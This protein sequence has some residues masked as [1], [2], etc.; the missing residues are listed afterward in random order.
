[1]G[2]SPKDRALNDALPE[3]KLL[4][5]KAPA[6]MLRHIPGVH[7]RHLVAGLA[8][9]WNDDRVVVNYLPARQ[10]KTKQA[11]EAVTTRWTQQELDLP[12]RPG[13]APIPKF[14]LVKPDSITERPDNSIA[15]SFRSSNLSFDAAFWLGMRLYVSRGED[16][17]LGT[18]NG[19]KQ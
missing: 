15:V 16:G 19:A 7:D 13:G 4:D 6:W 11:A 1:M 5:P 9:T 17:F 18:S 8:W 14:P 12:S 3:W 10:N 2:T